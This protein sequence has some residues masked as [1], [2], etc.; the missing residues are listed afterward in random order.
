MAFSPVELEVM[1]FATEPYVIDIVRASAILDNRGR[2][3]A[4]DLISNIAEMM[5]EPK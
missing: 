1:Y 3:L 2:R 4:L 5:P